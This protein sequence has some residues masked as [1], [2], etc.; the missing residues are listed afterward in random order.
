MKDKTSNLLR[1]AM[2]RLTSHDVHRYLIANT[3]GRLDGA[4]KAE[5]HRRLTEHY[6]KVWRGDE[7]SVEID[8]MDRDFATLRQATRALTD[9]LD[10][11]IGFP[12][13]SLRP[14]YDALA[15]AFFDKFHE[16]AI[17][18][19]EGPNF[20]LTVGGRERVKRL[21]VC[22][23]AGVKCRLS[24]KIATAL[25]AEA[26]VSE[27]A[28]ELQREWSAEAFEVIEGMMIDGQFADYAAA[29]AEFGIDWPIEEDS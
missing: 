26:E 13:A 20:P 15:P 24:G 23:Q 18:H 2:R 8:A 7:D 12:A 6:L 5:R 17:A 11:A 29:A 22:H 3:S 1:N 10:T 25:A 16:I 4:E 21:M 14:D 9:H 28:D 19:L 27:I